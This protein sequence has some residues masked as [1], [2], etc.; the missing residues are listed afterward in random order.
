MPLRA[1]RA[2]RYLR[3]AAIES[4]AERFAPPVGYRD[5]RAGRALLHLLHVRA[6]NPEVTAAKTGSGTRGNNGLRIGFLLQCV[7]HGIQSLLRL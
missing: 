7:I 5:Q 2:N 6:V 1:S 4:G 3:G